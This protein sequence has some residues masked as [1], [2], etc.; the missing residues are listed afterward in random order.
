MS[1]AYKCDRCSILFS[2]AK[3]NV[4]FRYCVGTDNKGTS[5]ERGGKNGSEDL[6]L[7]PACSREFLAFVKPIAP[8]GLA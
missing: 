3:G 8:R 4:G 7:C 6:D 5:E 2:P 1:L